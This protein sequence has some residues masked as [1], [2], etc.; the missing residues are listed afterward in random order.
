M[1]QKFMKTKNLIVGDM[2]SHGYSNCKIMGIASVDGVSYEVQIFNTTTN[3]DFVV[4]C[5]QH[6]M[7]IVICAPTQRERL[8][9]G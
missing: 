2:V 7:W 3:H 9:N 5:N 4:H 1:S 8:N 6:T